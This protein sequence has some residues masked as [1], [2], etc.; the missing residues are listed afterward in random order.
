[1][2][3]LRAAHGERAGFVF[4]YRGAPLQ[5][6]KTAWHSAVARAGIPPVRWHDLRHTWAS[7]HVMNGTPLPA[8][9]E[10]GGWATLEQVMIYAHLAPSHVADYAKTLAPLGTGTGT[11]RAKCG[12]IKVFDAVRLTLRKGQVARSIRV[13]GAK[14]LDGTR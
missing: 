11:G 4:T 2:Q 3:A 8:L 12:V 5:S 6:P 7:W 14:T 9:R 1:M 13:R 10:L